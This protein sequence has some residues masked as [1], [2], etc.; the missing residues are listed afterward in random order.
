[1]F[2]RRTLFQQIAASG[3]IY[4]YTVAEQRATRVL[5]CSERR[6]LRATT[7]TK[8]IFGTGDRSIGRSID[9]SKLTRRAR[10]RTARENQYGERTMR[11]PGHFAYDVRDHDSVSH[12]FG[13]L[14]AVGECYYSV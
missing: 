9:R 4:R 6:L 5:I 3:Q 13:R 10:E 2:P 8:E 12:V 14:R 11:H 7:T 1:M